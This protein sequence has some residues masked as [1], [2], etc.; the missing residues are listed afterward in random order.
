M[1]KYAQWVTALKTMNTA[2]AIINRVA[3]MRTSS[4]VLYIYGIYG[5]DAASALPK[6]TQMQM[7]RKMSL[8]V[9]RFAPGM[10][11]AQSLSD[12]DGNCHAHGKH[13][14]VEQV[15]RRAGYVEACDHIQ[16]RVENICV[17]VVIPSAH[18]S[19]FISSGVPF[20]TI[21]TASLRGILAD[22]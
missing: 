21:L 19:S 11:P 2:L 8:H 18:S 17:I 20:L 12:H 5:A 10:S 22:L 7:F 6:T 4:V 9:V 15:H 16:P 3:S 14:Y 13:D 1:A